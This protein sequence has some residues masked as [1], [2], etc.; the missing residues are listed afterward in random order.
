[1]CF[2]RNGMLHFVRSKTIRIPAGTCGGYRETFSNEYE[3]EIYNVKEN[4][5]NYC[6]TISTCSKVEYAVKITD[7]TKK[8]YLSCILTD[9]KW[10]ITFWNLDDYKKDF[11]LSGKF[12]NDRA[13]MNL[14]KCECN[15]RD[16]FLFCNTSD[17]RLKI[18]QIATRKCVFYEVID[19]YYNGHPIYYHY[20]DIILINTGRFEQKILKL[21]NLEKKT[22]VILSNQ[23]D[24]SAL[25]KCYTKQKEPFLA[26]SG[27]Y[28][29][30]IKIWNLTKQTL[31]NTLSGHDDVVT[32]VEFFNQN[33]TTYLASASK[34]NKLKIWDLEKYVIKNSLEI[35]VVEYEFMRQFEFGEQITYNKSKAMLLIS[36]QDFN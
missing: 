33:K 5:L 7:H 26:T 25:I 11:N 8:D 14:K 3:L 21:D 16:W 9:K 2:K 6:G 18:W 4:R 12:I 35:E 29:Y 17:K 22:S 36:K 24:T 19:S 34:D 30:N 31:E 1:M 20:E 15:G 27:R 13:L 23:T 28:D 10:E 32:A